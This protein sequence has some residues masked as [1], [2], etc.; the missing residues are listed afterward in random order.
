VC[1]GT[2]LSGLGRSLVF[3]PSY[4][5]RAQLAL[6]NAF[7]YL[8]C[9]SVPTD[10]KLAES[11]NVHL[12]DLAINIPDAETTRLSTLLYRT[13][14]ATFDPSSGSFQAP[15]SLEFSVKPLGPV[16]IRDWGTR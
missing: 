14:V 10:F 1:I 15:F 12:E 7:G 16:G 4:L 8:P 13:M 3:V 6:G 9:L 11:G 5:S 2:L